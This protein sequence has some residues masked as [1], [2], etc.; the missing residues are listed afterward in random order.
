M[1]QLAAVNTVQAAL[2]RWQQSE[3]LTR[4]EA[5]RVL[6]ALTEPTL[7]AALAGAALV[8][9]SMNGI[10]AAELQGMADGMRELA[11]RPELNNVKQCIDIVGTG[12]DGAHSFNISSGAALLLA[13]TGVTVIKHGNKA[14]SSRSGSADVLAALSIPMP[15]EAATVTRCVEELGFAFLYAP[16]YH[17][18]MKCVAP[19]RQALG[20][21]TIFNLLGPLTNPARPTHY[22]LGAYSAPVAAIIAQALQGLGIQRAFVIHSHNGWDEATTASAFTVWDVTPQKV[23]KSERNAAYYGLPVGR[24][25]DLKGGDAA[26]NASALRAV[27]TGVDQGAHRDALLIGAALGLEVMGI[28]SDPIKAVE[29]VQRTIE[30]GSAE[31]WLDR[32]I[33]RSQP[34]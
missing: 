8:A 30:D 33:A 34:Q 28:E 19:V 1:T 14:V 20:V 12:G 32:L 9:Q 15:M 24:E 26:A 27:F 2:K 21:R 10:D 18:A 16:H 5:H 7:P 29:R 13:A 31:R 6:L 4:Q 11:K 17:P 22:V 23:S 3:C 25:A